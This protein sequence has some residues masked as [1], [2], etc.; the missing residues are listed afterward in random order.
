MSGEKPEHDGGSRLKI[1]HRRLAIPLFHFNSCTGD[2]ILPDL[3]GE[4]L[5][6][7]ATAR[8][9]A[10]S[11]ARETLIEAVKSHDKAPDCIQVTDSRGREVLSVV[12][13]DLLRPSE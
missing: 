5:P 1:D 7:E 10:L 4:K 9:V 2:E 3:E 11:S 12:L 6:D 13:A 8:D